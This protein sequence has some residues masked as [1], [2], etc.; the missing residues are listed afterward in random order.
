MT[1]FS[2]NRIV[3][4]L[5]WLSEAEVPASADASASCYDF[6][7]NIGIL[8][9]VVRELKLREVERQIL[10][11]NVVIRPYNATLEQRPARFDVIR[12]DLALTYSRAL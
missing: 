8:A 6:A 3:I 12:V 2:R 1:P 4:A 5:I 10:L 11:G 9:V 7:E